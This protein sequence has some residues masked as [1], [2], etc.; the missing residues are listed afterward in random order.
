VSRLRMA[1]TALLELLPSFFADLA[2]LCR[3]LAVYPPPLTSKAKFYAVFAPAV[4]FKLLRLASIVMLA[5][6]VKRNPADIITFTWSPQLRTWASVD[7]SVTALDNAYVRAAGTALPALTLGLDTQPRSFC[8]RSSQRCGPAQ[9]TDCIRWKK[10]VSV[11]LDACTCLLRPREG[12]F[13][14]RLRTLFWFSVTN[15]VL[16]GASPPNT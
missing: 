13:G 1:M 8:G 9:N 12:S 6:Y 10:T 4:A 14:S 2:L 7:R 11:L 15:F 3:M 5:V 16:P